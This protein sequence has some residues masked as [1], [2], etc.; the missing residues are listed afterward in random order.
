MQLDPLD[1]IGG[2]TRP[3]AARGV[4]IGAL[5]LL[6]F[7]VLAFLLLPE[8]RDYALRGYAATGLPGA[9]SA[10]RFGALY[11][12][13]AV[14]PLSA[15]QEVSAD[16]EPKL[17]RLSQAPCDKTAVYA[18]AE[19]LTKAGA[20]RAA[21]EIYSGFASSCANSVEVESRAARLYLSLGD[22]ERA[23]ELAEKIIEEQP[24]DSNYHY[25]RGQAYAALKRY[26]QALVDYKKTI[27]LFKEPI[28]LREAVF[29][30]MANI[31]LAL[32][33]PCEAATTILTWISLDPK[34]R[35][36]LQALRRAGEYAARGC[37][38]GPQPPGPSKI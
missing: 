27:E 12:K 33:K 28:K 8:L 37:P 3:M 22:Y 15:A 7:L 36:T 30:E 4:L 5:T 1:R 31:Y 35:G 20:S 25:L 21:A 34:A 38:T 29:L 16:L 2:A 18:L 32:G 11:K 10:D 9:A 23:L 13:L 24:G 6:G 19:A 26:D 14:K 17:Q